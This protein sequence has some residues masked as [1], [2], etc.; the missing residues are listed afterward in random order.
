MAKEDTRKSPRKP[1]ESGIKINVQ[2]AE[3]ELT[4]IPSSDKWG[5]GDQQQEAGNPWMYDT[6]GPKSRDILEVTGDTGGEDFMDGIG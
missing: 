4:R 2:G 1:K 5:E 3:P 6:S